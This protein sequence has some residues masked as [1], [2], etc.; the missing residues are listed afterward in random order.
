MFRF[1]LQ[2]PKIGWASWITFSLKL[3]WFHSHI[4]GISH[5]KYCF[6][7]NNKPNGVDFHRTE[8]D[9]RG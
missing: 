3:Y 9:K 2:A 4:S 5:L 7:V 8:L 6:D 1:C